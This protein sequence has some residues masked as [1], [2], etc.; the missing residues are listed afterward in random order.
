M[1]MATTMVMMTTTIIAIRSQGVSDWDNDDAGDIN[2]RRGSLIG[3]TANCIGLH[4]RTCAHIV[5]VSISVMMI[6]MIIKIWEENEKVCKKVKKYFVVTALA[7]QSRPL[8]L[9]SQHDLVIKM[10]TTTEAL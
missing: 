10:S 5:I 6:M 8:T 7:P 2:D 9:G 4:A 3:T 1:M